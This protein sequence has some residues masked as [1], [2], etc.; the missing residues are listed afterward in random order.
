[1]QFVILDMYASTRPQIKVSFL[2]C[3]VTSTPHGGHDLGGLDCVDGFL[4]SVE[5]TYCPV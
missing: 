1:M 4:D 2:D 3:S 5:R